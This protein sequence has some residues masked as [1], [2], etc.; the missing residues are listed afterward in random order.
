MELREIQTFLRAADLQSFSKAAKQLGYSQA[1]VTIQIRNLEQ[2]LNTRLFDRIGRQTVLTHSGSIF[3]EYAYNIIKEVSRA[4]E[5]LAEKP[6]LTGTLCIGAIESIGSS[7]LPSLAAKYHERHPHVSVS[8]L[9]DSPEA[10]LNRLGQNTLDMVYLL[11]QKIYD[12]MFIKALEE[13]EMIVFTAAA[14]EPVSQ[15]ESLTLTQVIS[16]PFVLTEKDASYRFTLDQYL[17][18]RGQQIKPFL[19]IG[20]TDF[21]VRQVESGGCITFLPEYVIQDDIQKG[22]LKILPVEEFQMLLWRQL[23]YHKNKWVTREMQEF[24]SL[25]KNHS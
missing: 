4:K 20:N 2:E 7:I 3:Y 17:A 15:H 14:S 18:S 16:E 5:A 13:P 6:E 12:P 25:A 19:E 24:I 10:L 23:L 22:T 21:I 1:A 8:I 11:D 9:L